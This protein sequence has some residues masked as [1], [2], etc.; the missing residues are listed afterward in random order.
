MFYIL[1]IRHPLHG[2]FLL[3]ITLKISILSSQRLYSDLNFISS[4]L[5][6]SCDV[7]ELLSMI[8]F[9]IPSYLVRNHQLFNILTLSTSYTNTINNSNIIT[10]FYNFRIYTY[11]LLYYLTLFTIVY[12][13]LIF[14]TIVILYIIL[15]IT[16][17][18][19]YYP[20]LNNK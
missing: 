13:Y 6:S 15:K 4:L 9:R 8:N 16:R 12:L 7:P 20:L 1:K 18:G 17:S 14:N 2:Y 5:N 3:L 11:I 10:G 19:N